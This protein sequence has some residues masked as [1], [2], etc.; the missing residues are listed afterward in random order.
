[1]KFLLLSSLLVQICSSNTEAIC[2]TCNNRLNVSSNNGTYHSF[3]S[4]EESIVYDLTIAA[5]DDD[6]AFFSRRCREELMLIKEGIRLKDIWAFKR[7]CSISAFIN[8][9]ILKRTC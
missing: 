8:K 2:V 9:Q 4:V 7:K 3:F 6:I 1:M 5:N